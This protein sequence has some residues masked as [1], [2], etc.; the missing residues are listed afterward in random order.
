[1]K[2]YLHDSNAF[3]DEK[4]SELFMEFGYEGLG[5]FYTLLEKLASQE[6][7]IK[8][9]VL[10]A[11]LKVGKKLE[12][13][14]LFMES[15]KLIQSNNGETFNIQLMNFSEKYKIKS[16]NSAKRVLQFRERQ[17]VAK[18]V[19][20]YERVCNATKV[21]ES[22]VNKNKVIKEEIPQVEDEY[23]F[24]LI[25]NLYDKKR[26]DKSKLLKKWNSIS[27]EDKKLIF[28]HVPLY[29]GSTPEIQF[30]KDFDTYLNNKSWN[31]QIIESVNNRPSN[32]TIV[33]YKMK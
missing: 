27:L 12:R 9:S 30:R 31:D 21:K 24:N 16:E 2:Y 8:T 10:K 5:L 32:R 19:T 23:S 13:C 18:N 1:M 28:Q 6:K 25:W 3:N 20:R 15:I 29:K 4:V 33:R 26:G 11:Q 17:E 22:K 7:P 14:W